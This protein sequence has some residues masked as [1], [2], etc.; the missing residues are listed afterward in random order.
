[1]TRASPSTGHFIEKSLLGF[2]GS[3]F[4]M[5]LGSA[6]T[7][8]LVSSCLFICANSNVDDSVLLPVRD[9]NFWSRF[10]GLVARNADVHVSIVR[11]AFCSEVNSKVARDR[12]PEVWGAQLCPF[13]IVTAHACA[14]HH[15]SSA[16]P[17][18]PVAVLF[19]SGSHV[20][21]PFVQKPRGFSSPMLNVCDAGCRSR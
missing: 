17:Y 4:R 19:R 20:K 7:T 16:G 18:G 9:N 13:R 14:C 12:S 21:R 6:S 1:M 8:G 10:N 2:V 5:L 11:N 3:M 15:C